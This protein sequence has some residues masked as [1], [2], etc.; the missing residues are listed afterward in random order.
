MRWQLAYWLIVCLALMPIN[1]DVNTNTI[2][3]TGGASQLDSTNSAIFT[4]G[5]TF[6]SLSRTNPYASIIL[7]NPFGIVAPPPPTKQEQPKPQEQKEPPKDLQNL[8]L[9][10]ITTLVGKRAMFV[11]LKGQTNIYSSM[12]AEGER[13]ARIPELE[14]LRIDPTKGSVLI[15]FAG[16]EK[17][18]N[19]KEHGLEPPKLATIQPGQTSQSSISRSMGTVNPAVRN[20]PVSVSTATAQ[21]VSAQILPPQSSSSTSPSQTPSQPAV[22]YAGNTTYIREE[23]ISGPSSSQGSIQATNQS[24]PINLTPAQQKILQQIMANYQPPPPPMPPL[25]P[26]PGEVQAP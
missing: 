11:V 21:P 26:V 4:V 12:L 5:S 13:D 9:S 15:K 20:V 7:R 25:P 10:G 24:Q 16:I 22:I 17:E 6:Q 3:N 19:F 23:A 8:R 18:L 14:V 2:S 1:A